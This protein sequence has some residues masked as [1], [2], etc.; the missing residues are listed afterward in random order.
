MAQWNLRSRRKSTGSRYKRHG[1]KKRA[2][3]R[4]DFLPANIGPRKAITIRT[5]GGSAKRV[6]MK[7]DMANVAAAG[8]YKKVKILSVLENSAD[9]HFVRRNVITKG[10]I[11]NTEIGK[12][13]VLSRPGQSGTVNAI[14]LEEKK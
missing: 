6:L 1:K 14:L 2:D 9:S 7:T 5:R 13:K 11:I 4:R 3:R 12:A 8:K 10:A